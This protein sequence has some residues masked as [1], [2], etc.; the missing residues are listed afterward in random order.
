MFKNI[1]KKD[2]TAKPQTASDATAKPQAAKVK[3]TTAE[4]SVTVASRAKDEWAQAKNFR[5]ALRIVRPLVT[6]KSA[7]L[8]AFNK[9]VFE[10]HAGMNKIEVRKAIKDIYNVDPINVQVVNVSGKHVRYGRST[11]RTR[12]WKKAYVT[13]KSGDKIE[14]YEG[15]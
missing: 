6:E 1:F 3:K 14:I 11:G 10:V 13:L 12:D 4:K 2:Q 5:R 7:Q 9:Y 15:V 8:S